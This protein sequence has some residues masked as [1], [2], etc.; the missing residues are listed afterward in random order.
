M[1]LLLFQF[2]DSRVVAAGVA[3]EIIVKHPDTSVLKADAHVTETTWYFRP[4]FFYNH[5]PAPTEVTF[6]KDFVAHLEKQGIL[7]SH[8]PRIAHRPCHFK[9]PQ[10]MLTSWPA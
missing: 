7:L 8:G 2:S 4:S 5:T 9:A 10:D 3:F 1:S 6:V